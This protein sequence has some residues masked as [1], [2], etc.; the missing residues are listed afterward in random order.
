MLQKMFEETGALC[1]GLASASSMNKTGVE[2]GFGRLRREE[3]ARKNRLT[4]NHG[5]FY[6]KRR[7][8]RQSRQKLTAPSGG[9][10]VPFRFSLLQDALPS[11][12]RF[13][14]QTGGAVLHWEHPAA[15]AV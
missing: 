2:D 9:E 13:P 6:R 15:N 11:A 1:C 3:T 14:R 12:G 4:A 7:A 8:C 10:A 5:M